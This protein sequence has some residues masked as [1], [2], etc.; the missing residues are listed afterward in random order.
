MAAAERAGTE[1]ILRQYG[2]GRMYEGY[3]RYAA[4]RR[5]PLKAI[6]YV[7][8]TRPGTFRGRPVGPR[9][10]YGSVAR[11][12]GAAVTGEMKYFD[13]E[14]DAT[15][16]A[17]T[18]TAWPAGSM[19]D[20]STTINIGDAAIATPL[21]LF[22]PKVSA[23]LNGRI[24]RKCKMLKVKIR[25]L[26]TQPAQSAQTA[27]DAPTAVR[28]MLVQDKQTNAAQMTGAQLING[29]ALSNANTLQGFQNPN[30]FGRFRVLKDKIMSF[31]N[32]NTQSLSAT[33]ASFEQ[34]GVTRPFK[35]SYRFRKP[36]EVHFN[37]TNGGTVAD[38]IDHSLHVVAACNSTALGI[39]MTYYSR[40]SYKE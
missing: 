38:I 5:V 30:N 22:A 21:C 28:F 26:M 7:K 29:T 13:C 32:P 27:V 6:R 37:A 15:A 17:V 12:R 11:A 40:V 24:G 33:N 2:Y 14:L 25:G 4:S 3:Q 9:A 10:G 31:G 23:A 20:P 18:T 16:L 19:M 35:M 39:I 34:E 8:R 36:V 1:R